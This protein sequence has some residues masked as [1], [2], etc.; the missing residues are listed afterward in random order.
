MN[1]NLTKVNPA[2]SNR[3][4]DSMMKDIHTKLDLIINQ[5]TRHNE[6]LSKVEMD[7][8]KWRYLFIGGIS[9]ASLMGA[10]SMFSIL[11]IVTGV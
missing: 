9:V 1:V 3:E 11:K 8:N 7:I 10:P 4:I 2:Y 5:T 6:R